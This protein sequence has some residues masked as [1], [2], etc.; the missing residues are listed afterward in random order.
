[1]TEQYR[2]PE[3]QSPDPSVENSTNELVA[4]PSQSEMNYE[5]AR[6]IAPLEAYQENPLIGRENYR[7]VGERI[8]QITAIV[9][10][11]PERVAAD[12]TKFLSH[13]TEHDPERAHLVALAIDKNMTRLA[14]DRQRVY[15]GKRIWRKTRHVRDELGAKMGEELAHTVYDMDPIHAG[16]SMVE[17]RRMDA[18]E[19]GYKSYRFIKGAKLP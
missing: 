8:L 19:A 10:D 4:M 12:V 3:A 9:Q 14:A 18:V 15:A 5:I 16:L 7:A 1:M 11:N 17:S 6:S 13:R 2:V